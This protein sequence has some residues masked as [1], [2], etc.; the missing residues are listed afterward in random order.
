MED[1]C[2]KEIEQG[3]NYQ[4]ILRIGCVQTLFETHVSGLASGFSMQH[5]NIFLHFDTR[6]SQNLLNDLYD[7]NLDVCFSYRKFNEKNYR[8]IPFL[9]DEMILVTGCGNSSFPEGI[10][11]AQLAELP[12]V[13]E[14]LTCVSDAYYWLQEI[15]QNN[16]NPQMYV[17]TGSYAIPLIKSGN[18]YG[19]VVK[20]LV[21]KELLSGELKQIHLLEHDNP[22]LQSYLIYRDV[23]QPQKD[24]FLSYLNL[25][26]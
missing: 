18:G 17:G 12:L 9:Q 16:K 10:T 24:C 2:L 25:S 15:F 22:M 5:K 20:K 21:E 3:S 23:A 11:D 6:S 13:H 7:G 1:N 14:N 8:C 26:E 4:G 19:F